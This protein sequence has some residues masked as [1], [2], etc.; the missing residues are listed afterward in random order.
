[1]SPTK[2]NVVFSSS[3]A[4]GSDR[5]QLQR[6]SIGHARIA[7]RRASA[8]ADARLA[9]QHPTNGSTPRPKQKKAAVRV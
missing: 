2:S 3:D 1:M 4:C 5:P 8:I 9:S 7:P 6:R